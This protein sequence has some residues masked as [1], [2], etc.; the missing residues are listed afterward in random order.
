NQEPTRETESVQ[1]L[2][3]NAEALVCISED[4]SS[5]AAGAIGP[6]AAWFQHN[7]IPRNLIALCRNSLRRP[8]CMEAKPSLKM[9]SKFLAREQAIGLER[10]IQLEWISHLQWALPLA[11]QRTQPWRLRAG[12]PPNPSKNAYGRPLHRNGSMIASADDEL[13]FLYPQPHASRL[14]H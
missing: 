7:N 13:T 2:A 10:L 3:S 6:Q 9:L 1:P 8:G 12:A 4:V 11:M 5:A 14:P